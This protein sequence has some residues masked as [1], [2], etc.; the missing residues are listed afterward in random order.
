MWGTG[1][2]SYEAIGAKDVIFDSTRVRQRLESLVPRAQVVLLP[3]A[4]HGLTDQTSTV[5]EFLRT[6]QIAQ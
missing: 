6:A 4:G 2:F 3:G 1:S 5:L